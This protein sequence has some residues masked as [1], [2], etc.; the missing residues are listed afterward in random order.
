[1]PRLAS[2]RLCTGCLACVDTCKHQAI[3]IIKK[4]G[5]THISI[6]S[7]KCVNCN[8]CEK[9]CP[10]VSPVKK[11]DVSQ[12]RVYGGWC[13]DDT[14]RKKAASGGAFAGIALDFFRCFENSY[15]IGACLENNQVRHRCISTHKDLPLLMNSKY[16]QSDTKG[17]YQYVKQL[18]QS[19]A[20]V[21][22]SGTPCQIAGLYGYL[23]KRHNHLYTVEIICH[24]IPG[25][26]AL[27]LHLDHF[28]SKKIISFREKE[29]GQY[30]SQHTT[31]EINGKIKIIAR[32]DD[33]FYKIFAG[34]L[35]D[36]KS[37][38]NCKYAS[39]NRVSDI[40]IADFWGGPYTKEQFEKGVSLL[41]ANNEHG[42]NL[43]ANTSNL[44][45]NPS[46]IREAINSNTNLYDGFKFI[47]YHPLVLFPD[48]FRKHLSKEL[49]L[50]I[51]SNQI[52][53]KYF[54]AI[55]KI[56]TIIHIKLKKQFVLHKFKV[57]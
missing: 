19:N 34:W 26:E 52:P 22:F 15:V 47:Q 6:C 8:L 38:S 16:I 48:F 45:L 44:Q 11:N 1:M 17:I 13:K 10:I 21:L 2:D 57:K 43:L 36:R 33:L 46:T 50:H 32:K 53:Y 35:L 29:Y 28:K 5:V 14:L 56:L 54:W 7:D 23:R 51:I 42:H 3:D 37:C 49:W 30:A 25:Q 4:N 12:M 27:D 55:Y 41:I 39:L 40:T 20:Y 31:L 24:G 9:V 18:L